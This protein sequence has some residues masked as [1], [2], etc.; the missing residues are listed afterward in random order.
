MKLFKNCVKKLRDKLIRSPTGTVNDGWYGFMFIYFFVN[1]VSV[2]IGDNY[3]H[4]T[5]KIVCASVAVTHIS[6][7]K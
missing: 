5:T 2:G 3:T 7:G 6:H 4:N 1:V